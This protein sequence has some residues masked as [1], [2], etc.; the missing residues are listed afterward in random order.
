MLEG[1]LGDKGKWLLW[2]VTEGVVIDAD[3]QK[4]SHNAASYMLF[5]LSYFLNDRPM[6]C[7]QIEKGR[8]ETQ[9]VNQITNQVTMT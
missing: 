8:M 1:A 9:T 6:F 4:T 7:R 5:D 3:M 2:V